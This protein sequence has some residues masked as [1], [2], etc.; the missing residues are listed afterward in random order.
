MFSKS[1]FFG[2]VKTR[3][4]VA[5][6]Q[7]RSYCSKTV[8]WCLLTNNQILDWSNLKQIADNILKCIQNE[9]YVPYS[10]ENIVRKGEIYIFIV[11]QNAA[12][13]GNG[14]RYTGSA[15]SLQESTTLIH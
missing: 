5:M 3:D 8:P 2:I 4:Y 11:L 10:V 6:G 12:S 15:L 7:C 1:F 9:K 13:C 14:L